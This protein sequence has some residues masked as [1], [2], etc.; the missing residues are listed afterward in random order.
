MPAR[1]PSPT[2][3]AVA[4]Q[5]GLAILDLDGGPVGRWTDALGWVTAV[6][7]EGPFAW[8]DGTAATAPDFPN[9][10]P[11][12]ASG[13]TRTRGGLWVAGAAR[14]DGREELR[15]R[16][17]E[18]A[19]RLSPDASRRGADLDLAA[20]AVERWGEG[21]GDHLYGDFALTAWCGGAADSNAASH[22]DPARRRTC[23][24][25][26]DPLG[27]LPLYLRRLSARGLGVAL[28]LSASA[29]LLRALPPRLAGLGGLTGPGDL[30]EDTLAD[31]LLFDTPLDPQATAWRG[32]RALPAGHLLR[33]RV[34]AEGHG[35][36]ASVEQ[37]RYFDLAA[38][39]P[40]HL[41]L[42]TA[43]ER[44]REVLDRAVADRMPA[45]PGDGSLAGYSGL[46]VVAGGGLDG[47]LVAASLPAPG[48]L[49]AYS[50]QRLLDDDCGEWAHRVGAALDLPVEVLAANAHRPWSDRGDLIGH[51]ASPI[52]EPFFPV[53]TALARRARAD[54]CT[55]L[56]TGEGAD[57]LCHAVPDDLLS[58]L[59]TEPA[60]AVGALLAEG[61][62]R[63]RPPR[64]GLR[65]ALLRR[66]GLPPWPAG[67]TPWRP[68]YPSWLASDFEREYRLR[69]RWE[70]ALTT[71]PPRGRRAA[72]LAGL[73]HPRAEA[74]HRWYDVPAA[75]AGVEI[76]H[77]FLDRRVVECLL[78]L[79]PHPHCHRKEVLRRAARGRLPRDVRRR[80]KTLLPDEPLLAHLRD[81]SWQRGEAVALGH[82]MARFV[83]LQ[84]HARTL[85]G[86]DRLH[87]WT[88]IRPISLH[89]WLQSSR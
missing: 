66:L 56:L 59:L 50:Y 81:D 85:E 87:A 69:Q 4:A 17:G 77:P 72:A 57:D 16:L 54:G 32:L 27:V 6:A 9:A 39:E 1:F 14:L 30:D 18:A 5:P 48:R 15:H 83:N 29:D 33:V 41:S 7:A 67:A 70:E 63:R 25:F 31:Y 24:A 68:T 40:L 43:A 8:L 28:C 58:W 53:V 76:R 73:T 38:I 46:G 86:T 23:L 21:A 44:L 65:S 2:K 37:R 88:D 11:A 34:G 10:P 3:A 64:L 84:V 80:P 12:H 45:G 49:Y 20:A 47:S 13:V 22:A 55:V 71:P 19:P 60:T 62:A 26:R 74:V 75:A 89:W 51:P 35:G 42:D 52:N 79:P 36:R 61:L 82:R 78:A